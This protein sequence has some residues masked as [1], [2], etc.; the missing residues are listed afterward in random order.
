MCRSSVEPGLQLG[1]E[2]LRTVRAFQPR[3]PSLSGIFDLSI[4]H[5]GSHSNNLWRWT[6]RLRAI[7]RLVG[8]L[9]S[10]G[11]T[12]DRGCYGGMLGLVEISRTATVVGFYCEAGPSWSQEYRA[13]DLG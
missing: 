12:Y 7:H 2:I 1:P 8:W 4:S 11:K 10:Q 9:H 13:L 5:C 3:Y 6:G